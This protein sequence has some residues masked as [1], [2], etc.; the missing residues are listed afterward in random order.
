MEREICAVKTRFKEE[1][2]KKKL[3]KMDWE[4][5]YKLDQFGQLVSNQVRKRW[6]KS[7]VQHMCSSEWEVHCENF[8]KY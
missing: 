4:E 8:R 3:Q 6:K 1:D 7:F 2:E 5:C